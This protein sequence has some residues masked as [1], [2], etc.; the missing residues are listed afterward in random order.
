MSFSDSRHEQQRRKDG[1]LRAA[2]PEVFFAGVL[3]PGYPAG[4]SLPSIIANIAARHV[5]RI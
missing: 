4:I 3:V 5:D 2:L 1:S